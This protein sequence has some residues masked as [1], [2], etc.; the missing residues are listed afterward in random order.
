MSDI[1]VL[2]RLKTVGALKPGDQPP[3]WMNAAG[4]SW[5]NP[6]SQMCREAAEEIERL[7]SNAIWGDIDD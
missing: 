3:E 7:R 6:I 4:G 1:D 5:G 2:I